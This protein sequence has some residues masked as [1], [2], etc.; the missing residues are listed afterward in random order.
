MAA[1]QHTPFIVDFFFLHYYIGLNN[2]NVSLLWWFV[3]TLKSAWIWLLSWKVHAA[4]EMKYFPEKVLEN[5][6][7][8]LKKWQK[9]LKFLLWYD[10]FTFNVPFLKFHIVVGSSPA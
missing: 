6:L 1:K 4:L 9:S 10:F 2:Y 7:S 5:D 8:D 3:Q